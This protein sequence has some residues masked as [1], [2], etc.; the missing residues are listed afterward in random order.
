MNAVYNMCRK[1]KS[2]E[3]VVAGSCEAQYLQITNESNQPH[4]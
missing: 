1:P 3:T 4:Y 2:L